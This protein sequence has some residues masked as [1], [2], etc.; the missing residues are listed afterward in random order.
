MSNN[1]LK[2]ELLYTHSL[3]G[4]NKLVFNCLKKDSSLKSTSRSTNT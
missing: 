3:R 1:V 2:Y 4:P